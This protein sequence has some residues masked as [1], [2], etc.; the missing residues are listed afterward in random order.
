MRSSRRKGS[1]IPIKIVIT[2]CD[3]NLVTNLTPTVQLDKVDSNPDGSV[4]EPLITEVATN[5]KQMRWLDSFYHYTL[6]TKNSQFAA[7]GAMAA[8]TWRISVTDP[9]LAAPASV[10]VDLR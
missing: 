2:D 4:N 1:T 7:G 5:G 6:S 9:S 10:I 3:G 8:G